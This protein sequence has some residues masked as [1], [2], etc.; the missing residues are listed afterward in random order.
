MRLVRWPVGLLLLLG[1]VTEGRGQVIVVPGPV[2][3]GGI[4]GGRSLT[5]TQLGRRAQFSLRLQ[6]FGYYTP[7]PS[8]FGSSLVIV[9]TPPPPPTIIIP[10]PVVVAPA[11]GDERPDDRGGLLIVPHRRVPPAEGRLEP[12]AP[13]P[14]AEMEAPPPEPPAAPEPPLPGAPASVF[15]PIAPADRE[16]ALQPV[17]PVPPE[18]PELPEPPPRPRPPDRP[19]GLPRPML[20]EADP[21]AE[22]ARQIELG[23]EAFAA[24]E[25]ARA[26]SRFRRATKLAAR[27]PMAH[28]LLAQALFAIGK[29]DEAVESIHAGLR[30]RPD[31][32]KSRFRAAELYGPNAAEFAEHLKRLE[33]A[34]DR[35]PDDPV[36]LFLYGYQLWFDGRQDEAVPFFR[37]AAAVAPDKTDIE[38]FLNA[39]LGGAVVL[40]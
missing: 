17:P 7:Y 18:P 3:V 20:P 30:L 39:R 12:G 38:R 33:A 36:L 6:S 9:S 31:W 29:Y 37:R 26:F 2:G 40:R 32:P 35:H 25:Y 15:R 1:A 13:R 11:G 24:E 23:K 5:Y 27:E 28:F 8:G 21:L 14:R 4:V 34:V 10:Q 19:P 16:R 22:S